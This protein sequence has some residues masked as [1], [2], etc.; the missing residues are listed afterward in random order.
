[1][2]ASETSGEIASQL[3]SVVIPARDEAGVIGT[4]LRA[5]AAQRGIAQIFLV[6]DQSADQTAN[7]ARELNLP[8]LKVIDGIAPPPGWSGKLWAL[9]QGLREVTTR[10]TLLLDADIALAPNLV[11][12]LL[13]KLRATGAD[14]VSVMARLKMDSFWEG[15]LIPPFIYFFKLLY[16]FALA[17][18]SSK[19]VA[20]AAGGCILINTEM[21]RRIG[22]VAALRGALIDDCALA[23]CIK[24][25]GG[26][27]W[28]GLSHDVV[29][30]RPYG[31]LNGI[32]NMVA[33]TAFTQLRYST[34]LLALCTV[35]M[36]VAFCVP[37]VG[38]FA[39]P[40]RPLAAL[41]LAIMLITYLPVLTY[42]RRSWL[43]LPSLPIAG[44]FYLAMTW[45][46]A[47]RYLRGER[48]RWKDRV[49]HREV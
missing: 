6:D 19:T 14:L 36:S 42:Y 9:D 38:L 16:P 10:Y 39:S 13:D 23:R 48:S 31:G 30:L 15:L 46:S 33:R 3:I 49:Y 11:A 26:R 4:T 27:V 24:A 45:T 34:L 41:T 37:I 22:G 8:T 2:S 40:T 35:L 43:W 7:R 25:H 44:V 1:I 28:L 5:V 21:L 18:S 12:A 47:L 32:W 29:A 17:N 20:A